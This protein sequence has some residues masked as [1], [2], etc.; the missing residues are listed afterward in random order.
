MGNS[1]IHV[2]ISHYTEPDCYLEDSFN[3][4]LNGSQGAAGIHTLRQL[5]SKKG[6]PV[7]LLAGPDVAVLDRVDYLP[8]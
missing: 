7:T 6:Y 2:N 4:V 8:Q 1:N 5:I 3:P